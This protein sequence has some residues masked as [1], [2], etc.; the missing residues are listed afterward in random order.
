VLSGRPQVRVARVAGW[1]MTACA[2][3]GQ[4]PDS[5]LPFRAIL[6]DEAGVTGGAGATLFN[7][8]REFAAELARQG[9]PV[10][11]DLGDDDAKPEDA[12]A[13]EAEEAPTPMAAQVG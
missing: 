1:L 9:E 13:H 4:A 7:D 3:A 10:P 11:A 2:P 6:L 12:A 5:Q 8:R